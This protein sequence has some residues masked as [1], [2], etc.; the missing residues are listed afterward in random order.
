[1]DTQKKNCN[2]CRASEGHNNCSIGYSCRDYIPLEPCPK[3][4]TI[5]KL[6]EEIKKHSTIKK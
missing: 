2:G 5:P 6:I 1:M 3:P 4:K